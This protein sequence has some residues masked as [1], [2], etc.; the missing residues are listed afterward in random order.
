M[1]VAKGANKM[2]AQPEGKVRRSQMLTTYG[3]GA[4]VDLLD[5]A[6]II[7]GLDFWRFGYQGVEVVEE[8][9]L[10]D[11]VAVRLKATG[12]N[13]LKENAFRM[14]PAGDDG[15]PSPAH[16]V[17]ARLFPRWFVCNKCRGLTRYQSLDFKR[18]RFHHDCGSVCVPV[19]FV[20]ACSAGHIDDLNWIGIVHQGEPCDAVS[21]KLREGRTGDFS[22]VRV[23]CETCGKGRQLKDLK[24]QEMQ[25]FCRGGQPW[26]GAEG[27]EDCEKRA[28]LVVRTASST[29]FS[30]VDSALSI[31]AGEDALYEAV[32]GQMNVLVAATAE[33]LPGFRHIP[34]VCAAIAPYTDGEVLAT[35]AMIKAGKKPERPP[36]RIEEFER[37]MG[38][39][40]E[41]PGLIAPSDAQFFARRA[42]IAPIPGIDRVV[43]AHKLREVRVQVGFTRLDFP[44]PSFSGEH[45]LGV[46]TAP[47]GLTTDWLPSVEVFGEGVFL[48]L[49]EEAVQDWERRPEVLEREACLMEAHE[50]YYA[51]NGQPP[52]FPGARFY[53]LHSLAHLLVTAVS[54]E[55]GYSASAI[56]ERIYCAPANAAVPMAAILLSTGTPGTEGTL[57]GLVNQG[58]ALADHLGRAC[59]LGKLCSNDPV[60]AGRDPTSP[61][62]RR[63]DGAACHGCLYIAES[64]CEFFNRFLDRAFVVPTLGRPHGL[65]YFGEV[66]WPT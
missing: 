48:A 19:R 51:S 12:Q 28:Q 22:E 38:E 7:N 35:V 27:K 64:S 8:P 43:L 65:A 4:L 55:C 6:V 25:P 31:P 14:P 33:L 2:A 20:Q 61:G 63:V 15:N 57:G 18:G 37:F 66:G 52:V 13:L 26:L 5:Y 40:L 23:E 58:R 46:R 17:S 56:R 44:A 11:R 9:R 16:G 29:Y 60:C 24:V 50:R 30:Q 39:P 54:L 59:E 32:H 36:I 47:L 45:D 10:R 53:L 41:T 21:L 34:G 49:D 1:A 42:D 3:P 62:E